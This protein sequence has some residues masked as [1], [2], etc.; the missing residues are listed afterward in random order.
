V[1]VAGAETLRE[2][3]RVDRPALAALA[4]RIGAVRL[5]DNVALEGSP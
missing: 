4:A 5:I 3:D 2:L 1:S